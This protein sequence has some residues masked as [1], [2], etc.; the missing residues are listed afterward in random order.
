MLNKKLSALS[1]TSPS[2]DVGQRTIIRPLARALA[3]LDAFD[4]KYHWLSNSDLC[5]RTGLPASTVSRQT[6]CLVKLGYL[7]HAP[8]LRK[9]SLDSSVLSLGYAAIAHSRVQRLAAK[10]MR[11]LADKHAVHVILST[12]DRLNLIVV[13]RAVSPTSSIALS[14]NVG[15]RFDLGSSP[16]GW[17]LLA[18][19]PDVEQY[20]LLDNIERRLPLE[21]SRIKR[22]A[23]LAM[24]QVKNEGYCTSLGEWNS[25]LG[26]V[27]T[28]LMVSGHAPLVIAC[29]GA[30]NYLSR[31][32]VE[33]TLGPELVGIA[34]SI[35]EEAGES[36]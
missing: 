8:K 31:T 6:Q 28:P 18:A 25:D 23:S 20:Y 13:E 21:W 5:E 30:S 19:L 7:R 22:R 27:A 26:T 10:Q 12:R 24:S 36:K 11:T 33:R 1:T 14:V 17:A 3:L 35:Q 34:M 29:I 2:G 16:I 4:T 9:Y 15:D 32:R